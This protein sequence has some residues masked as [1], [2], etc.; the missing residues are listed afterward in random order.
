MYVVFCKSKLMVVGIFKRHSKARL[1]ALDIGNALI[2]KCNNK[3]K[4]KDFIWKALEVRA[5]IDKYEIER[6][7]YN[8]RQKNETQRH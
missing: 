2:L 4:I 5:F 3:R 7:Q 8:R 1:L 6:A